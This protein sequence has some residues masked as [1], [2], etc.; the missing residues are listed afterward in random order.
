MTTETTIHEGEVLDQMPV[1]QQQTAMVATD[2]PY[3]AM[4]QQALALGKVDQLD[5]L[6]DLQMRW[7][8]EQARKAFVAAMAAF[9]AEPMVIGKNKQVS[10]TTSKGKTEY[11]HAEL[12]DITAVV[13]P[14]MAKHGLSHR[15][16]I[17]QDKG[18]TV[19]C[20]VTHAGGHSETVQMTAPA[21][22]SGGKNTIQSIGSTKSYLERYT[23]LAATGMATGGDD[24]DGR[25]SEPVPEL[26][27]ITEEQE[28]I[29][30]DLM[31]AYVVNKEAFYKW[32]S[33]AAK[34]PVEKLSEIPA[35][36]YNA[37][38]NQLKQMREKK[39]AKDGTNVA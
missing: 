26:S 30:R 21:D 7:D 10:F 39:L 1:A 13:V 32:I 6:L 4:A 19:T 24:D 29:L 36:T 17:S 20:I 38:H 18:I 15:W 14:M 3:M 16:T 8:G 34:M 5:K 37:V 33:N 35:D 28:V 25:T 23:L 12:S 27:F 31:D 2:N 9:K 22:D 11:K